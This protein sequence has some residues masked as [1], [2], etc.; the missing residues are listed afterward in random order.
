[1]AA[2]KE[3]YSGSFKC[4]GEFMLK[5]PYGYYKCKK[6]S[7][8]L[9]LLCGEDVAKLEKRRISAQPKEEKPKS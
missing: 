7:T 2:A 9:N 1:M 8:H 4:C 6:C 3:I 5:L